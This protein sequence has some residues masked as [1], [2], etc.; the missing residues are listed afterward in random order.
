[1][2]SPAAAALYV[3]V[4][5]LACV[6]LAWRAYWLISAEQR[7]WRERWREVDHQRRREIMVSL[8]DGQAVTGQDAELALLA[9]DR[10]EYTRRALRPITYA[11]ALFVAILLIAGLILGAGTAAVLGAVGLC[12]VGSLEL[13]TRR[14]MA[15]MH[16]AAAATRRALQP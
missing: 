9:L 13:S 12:L 8:R 1:M 11:F 5:C 15:R 3:G 6:A 7:Q 16:E 10:L 2:S 14:R 4:F